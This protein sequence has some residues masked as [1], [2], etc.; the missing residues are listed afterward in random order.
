M[1]NAATLK[2]ILDTLAFCMSMNTAAIRG[3][4]D[5]RNNLGESGGLICLFMSFH[6]FLI[7]FDGP[8]LCRGLLGCSPRSC[9][10]QSC[11]VGPE[12]T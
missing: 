7:F 12:G 10:V 1:G 8:L 9:L 6:V 4:R 5:L 2:Y 3:G 11:K